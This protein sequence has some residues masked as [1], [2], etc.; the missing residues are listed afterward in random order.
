VV[1]IVSYRTDH[2]IKRDEYADAGIPYYWIVD[3][4]DPVT[5]TAC[6]LAGEFGYQD[7]GGVTDRFVTTELF[8]SA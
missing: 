8:P 1:E 4:D 7:A 3:L 2:V 5:L 6:H